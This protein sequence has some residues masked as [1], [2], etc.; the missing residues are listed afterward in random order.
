MGMVAGASPLAR[1]NRGVPPFDPLSL[2]SD[3]LVF[4]AIT[5][6]QSPDSN[7]FRRAWQTLQTWV[8]KTPERALDDAYEAILRIRA[9]EDEHFDGQP[10]SPGIKDYSASVLGY[11]QGEVNKY[12]RIARVRLQEFRA[13]ETILNLGDRKALGFQDIRYRT[14]S[15]ERATTIL[16]KLQAIDAMIA[17]YRPSAYRND[18]S[19]RALV[20]LAD[21]NGTPSDRR[22]PSS[23]SPAGS[24]S[25]LRATAYTTPNSSQLNPS[26]LNPSQPKSTPANPASSNSSN[27]TAPQQRYDRYASQTSVLPRSIFGTF[28]RLRRELDPNAEQN[29]VSSFRYSKAQTILSLRFILVLILVPLLIHHLSKAFVVGPIVDRLR[30]A[31]VEQLF[32]NEDME[33]EAYQELQRYESRLKF[34]MMIHTAPEL[35]DKELEDKIQKQAEA[36]AES[37][38]WRGS[39]AIKNIFSDTLTALGFAIILL[40]SR[41]EVA[42]LKGFMDEVVYGLSDS[43]KAFIIILFT[44]IFVGF[45]SP[46]GWE[47]VLEGIARH[48]GLPE[49]RS[50]IFLF[51][52]TFPVIL[53][54]VFKYWIFRY[55]NRISPSAVATYRNMNE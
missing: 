19:S 18:Q 4:W 6:M 24:P 11:F 14:E 2:D 30:N 16:E 3:A 49:S 7:P 41:R 23:T 55:L 32:L 26:Q 27:R 33:E 53:D 1:V 10:V 42:L 13:S 52:A 44:D 21:T 39:N 17:R 20:P 50:F 5:P 37:F 54:T 25:S 9:L 28:D 51:I 47:V 40:S 46:H 15:Q 35:S 43:A 29:L 48:F 38:R 45:H 22:R 12:L 31:E 8:D 34:Q 36:I